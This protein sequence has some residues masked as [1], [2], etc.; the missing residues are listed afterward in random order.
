MPFELKNAPPTFQR[1]MDLSLAGMDWQHCL[2]YLDDVCLFSPT[3]EHHEALVGKVF[4]KRR[5]AS[6]KLKPSK[7]Q[8]FTSEVVFLGHIIDKNGLRPDPTNVAKVKHWRIPKNPSELRSFFGLA[9]YYRKFCKD[10][11][12]KTAVLYQMIMTEKDKK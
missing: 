9:S 5:D 7:C 4:Q 12:E 1:L 11:A 10:F 3:F 2:V 6:L 8:L